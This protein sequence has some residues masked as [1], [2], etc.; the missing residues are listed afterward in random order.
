MVVSAYIHTA[1][2]PRQQTNLLAG[3]VAVAEK[4]AQIDLAHF[5]RHCCSW[6]APYSALVEI[7]YLLIS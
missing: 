5:V 6:L 1:A 4:T 2:H 7:H 3:T